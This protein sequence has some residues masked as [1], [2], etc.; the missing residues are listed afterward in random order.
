MPLV[1]F[2]S[3]TVSAR[4]TERI[5]LLPVWKILFGP[6]LLMQARQ[7]R[8]TTLRLPEAAGPREG[9][10]GAGQGEPLR[11]LVVG[12][13]SAA[14]V[15][16]DCQ[17]AAFAQPL[18]RQLSEL[19]GRPVQWQLLGKTGVNSAEALGLVRDARLD[20]AD[21]LV[22]ALGTNDVTAQRSAERYVDAIRRLYE[23]V[24]ARTGAR[25]LVC[26]GL[27]PLHILPA[28]PQPLRW[29]LGQCAR[30]LDS[31]LQTWIEAQPAARYCSL[32][33]AADPAAMARDR[34]HPG[35]GQ[36]R[37]WA[38]LVARL[39]HHDLLRAAPSGSH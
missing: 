14:G 23:E 32:Q 37:H 12:D 11:V 19:S 6:L 4:L 38:S 28:A 1:F 16:V 22:T 8:R 9:R 10:E 36:Y 26:S 2:V 15:G 35:A 27:P 24:R 18:A 21:V 39:I 31:A 5:P 33:W 7:V 17:S 20:S 34:F 25:A 29:Y 3:T 30:R 13:S